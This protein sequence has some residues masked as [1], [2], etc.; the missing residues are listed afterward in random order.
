MQLRFGGPRVILLTIFSCL[1][2]LGAA[3]AQNSV[4]I[5]DGAARP[6]LVEFNSAPTSDGGTVAGVEN[7]K[8]SFH[9]AAATAKINYVER[10]SFNNLFS[11]VAIRATAADVSKLATLPGVK[12]VYPDRQLFYDP[13]GGTSVVDM[14]TAVTMTGAD[15]VYN[16]LHITGK[17]VKVAVIDTGIDYGHPDLGAC[18]SIGPGCRVSKG[19]D[20][21]G[22]A[23]D[24]GTNPVPVP[25]PDPMDCAGHG[26][27]V[28]GIIGANGDP[29]TGH[30]RGVAPG[31]TFYAYRVFG[32]AGSTL[33][34]VMIEAMERALNDGAQV[35]NM[36]IGAALGWPQWPTAMASDRLVKH[37]VVVVAS[38]GNSGTGQPGCCLYA[39]GAPGLGQE[40]ISVASFD[41][42][43]TASSVL[44]IS[45]DNK[46]IGY[47][48]AT[49]A[50][51]APISGTFTLART[52][53]TASTADGC[54]ALPSQAG[55][56]VLIR[57]GTCSFYV[58]AFNAQSAGAA[59]VILYNNTTGSLFPTVLPGTPAITIPVVAITA[60]DGAILDGRIAGGATTM[61]WTTLALETPNTST[62]NLIS[63]FS[64][65]GLSPDLSFKPDIGAPGGNI[66]STYPRALG[67]YAVLSGTSMASPHVAG[68][69][70][71]LLESDR[72]LHAR[73]VRGYLM[74]TA[75]PHLWWGNPALG[76]LDST[77]RQGAGMLNI[78]DAIVATTRLFPE[79]LALGE[80][81]GGPSVVAI[82]ISNQGMKKVTY[83]LSFENGLSTN[84]TFAP[85]FFSSDATVAF[86]NAS[87]TVAA[88]RDKEIKVVITPPTGPDKALYGGWIV[89]TPHDGDGQV[90]RVPFAGFVGDYQSIQALAPTAN[91]FPWLAKLIGTSLF[92]QT[93]GAVY[94]LASGDVPYVLIH[95]DHQVQQIQLKVLD[96][97]TG[98]S[99]HFIDN[100]KYIQ[101]NS[102]A[103]GFFYWTFD[104]TTLSADLQRTFT[105]PNGNYVIEVRAL[106]ALGDRFNPADWE[107]W[108]SPNFIIARP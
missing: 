57:R 23:F 105:V 104:G 90:L 19:Y 2:L 5:T 30:V 44:T 86:T 13:Q 79:K 31:V 100:S 101:R 85:A 12:A 91:G 15:L 46:Q 47:N 93:A 84:N 10:H 50:P 52:G 11:G 77:F 14:A 3:H 75:V 29:A 66:R 108:T 58:K 48:A 98:H 18:G 65:Y 6:W 88:Q 92:K 73:E 94:T 107:T 40:V 27:H 64:S 70:A 68:A 17:G 43:F 25:D 32:C 106:K 61:T 82:T 71:L 4:S 42:T 54:A 72:K 22:D 38:F 74:S 7:D 51:P 69:A 83:D 95:F 81:Q 87:V 96:A 62:G 9:A 60:S 78:Y 39:G 21:V 89:L 37:G 26:S 24:A 53:T 99:M 34:S 35:V 80:S 8:A 103:S 59:G 56:V 49:G 63:S 67:S 102:T 1:L 28:A 97:V 33:D 41:N 55:K 45:P 20:L 76:F 16:D 36:S